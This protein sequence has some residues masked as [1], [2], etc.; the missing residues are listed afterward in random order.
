MSQL[1]LASS[2]GFSSPSFFCNAE[3]NRNNKHFN[4][5]HILIISTILK[6][7]IHNLIPSSKELELFVKKFDNEKE[8]LGQ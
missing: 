8:S 3:A 4:I 5:E 2:M 1:D 6:V 7:D